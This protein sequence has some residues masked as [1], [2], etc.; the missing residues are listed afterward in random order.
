M[1]LPIAPSPLL[2]LI[3]ALL[4]S[5]NLHAT[6][7]TSPQHSYLSSDTNLLLASSASTTLGNAQYDVGGK[8]NPAPSNWSGN[9]IHQYL[10][11]ASITLA[12][13]SVLSPKE[14]DGPHEL[15]AKGAAATGGAAI[16]SGYWVHWND[17]SIQ[18]GWKDPDNQH[19]LLTALGTLGYLLAVSQ[20]PD[21]S[22]AG[23][24]AVGFTAMAVGIRL[25]W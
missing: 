23:A 3:A 6:E 9:K 8:A 24:G 14:E 11:L 7:L 12:T 16:A 20:A 5:L 18:D 25:T 22:H 21:E 17:F 15:F 2:A 13:L 10:G 1:T 4:L 19:L